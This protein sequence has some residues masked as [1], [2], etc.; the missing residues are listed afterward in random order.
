[1]SWITTQMKPAKLCLEN[2]GHPLSGV[3]DGLDW[4]LSGGTKQAGIL[5]ATLICA[6]DIDTVVEIGMWQGFTSA[7]L[8]KALACNAEGSGLL[9]SIDIKEANAR[10]GQEATKGLPIEHR[11]V[12]SDS[13][14]V[15]L[16][17]LLAGRSLGLAFVDGNH[18]YEYAKSDIEMCGKALR[19]NGVMFVHDYSKAGFPGVWQAVNEYAESTGWPVLFMDENRRTTDYRT[20]VLQKRE[21]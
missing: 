1:M 2:P 19:K 20:A 15:D 8:G 12:V 16:A 4:K 3:F 18:D 17:A 13:R 11:V 14:A 10:R 21:V 6:L 7:I 5:A 9:L